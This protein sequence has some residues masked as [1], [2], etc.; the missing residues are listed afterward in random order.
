MFRVYFLF[1]CLLLYCCDFFTATVESV[2]VLCL[3]I[4]AT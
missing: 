2:T 1:P 4:L 3:L